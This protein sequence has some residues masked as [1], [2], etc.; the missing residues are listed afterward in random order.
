[1]AVND[2][3]IVIEGAQIR[4]R[5]F[6]GKEGMYNSEGDRNFV[7]LLEDE[8]AEQLSKDGWNIK[9]LKPREEG[10]KPQ[11][12]M[13]VSVKYRGRNGTM[14]RPP[15]VVLV[16]SRGKTDIGE[17]LV[18]TLDWVDIRSADL[19]IRPYEWAVSGKSGIKAYLKSLYITIQEDA[20]ELKYSDVPELNAGAALELTA[21]EEDVIDAEFWEEDDKKAIGG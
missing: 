2:G 21:G 20:L 11:P 16:T 17:D 19:I 12:Y 7:V 1:M 4:F 18:E 6:A 3:T 13:S 5:N 9:T 8:L 14:T 10:D 15:R